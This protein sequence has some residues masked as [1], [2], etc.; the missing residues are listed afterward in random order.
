MKK[1]IHQIL[2]ELMDEEVK[3]FLKFLATTLFLCF[4]LGLGLYRSDMAKKC[5]EMKKRKEYRKQVIGIMVRNCN[6]SAIGKTTGGFVFVSKFCNGVPEIEKFLSLATGVPE[7]R[8]A[9]IFAA[10]GVKIEV[11]KEKKIVRPEIIYDKGKSPDSPESEAKDILY[12]VLLREFAN[13]P[14]IIVEK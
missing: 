5:E 2:Q 8:A 12:E 9:N 11:F 14:N 3:S 13:N 10:S 6:F 7:Y 4:L 1:L